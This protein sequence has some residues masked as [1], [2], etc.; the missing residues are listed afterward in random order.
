MAE[1]RK[2]WMQE[3]CVCVCVCWEPTAKGLHAAY[4]PEILINLK[5][6]VTEEDVIVF[7]VYVCV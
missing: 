4:K 5:S 6:A 3:M 1:C 7:R 2:I